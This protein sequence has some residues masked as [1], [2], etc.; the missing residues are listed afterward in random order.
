MPSIQPGEEMKVDE[1]IRYQE[2]NVTED[3]QSLCVDHSWK[4]VFTKKD[5]CGDQFEVLPKMVKCAVPLCHSN[6]DVER[7][8][9]VNKRMLTK[10]NLSLRMKQLWD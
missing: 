7:S 1:W 6:A 2:I 9:S 8:L 3:D 4:K 5:N 10:Q